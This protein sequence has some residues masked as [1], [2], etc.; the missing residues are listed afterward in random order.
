MILKICEI[1]T[2]LYLPND[3]AVSTLL[4]SLQGYVRLADVACSPNELAEKVG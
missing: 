4:E 1:D 3:Y 2:S